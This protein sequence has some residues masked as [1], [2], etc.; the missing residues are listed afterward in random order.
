MATVVG[1]DTG[2]SLEF[3]SFEVD[4]MREIAFNTGKPLDIIAAERL[5]HGIICGVEGEINDYEL[6]YNPENTPDGSPTVLIKDEFEDSTAR[7]D[8]FRDRMYEILTELYNVAWSN[9]LFSSG[10]DSEYNVDNSLDENARRLQ[11]SRTVEQIMYEV[12]DYEP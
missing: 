5:S 2:L 4:L 7:D 12:H 3:T 9:G 10:M 6:T 11:V 1:D 8:S